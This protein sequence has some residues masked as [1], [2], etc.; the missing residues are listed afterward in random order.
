MHYNGYSTQWNMDKPKY[1]AG[2]RYKQGYDILSDELPEEDNIYYLN[3][4][5]LQLEEIDYG[6]NN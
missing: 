2:K 4:E 5:T 3:K 6:T 1:G